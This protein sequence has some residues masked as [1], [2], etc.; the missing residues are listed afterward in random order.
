MKELTYNRLTHTSFSEQFNAFKALYEKFLFNRELSQNEIEKALSISVLFSNQG[1][2]TLNKIGY[3]IALLYAINKNDFKPLYDICINTGITPVADLLKRIEK[4]QNIGQEEDG[5][6]PTII[7]SFIDNFRVGEIVQTEQQVVLNNFHLEKIDATTT[8]VAPTSYGKSELIISTIQKETGKKICILVPSKSLLAQTKRRV[9]ESNSGWINKIITHPDMYSEDNDSSLYIL[10]QERLSRLINKQK[11]FYLDTVFIDEAHNILEKGSRSTLLAS[12]LRVLHYRNRDTAFKFLTPFLEDPKNINLKDVELSTF[13]FKVDEY[14]KAENV[15]I[16]D[17]RN[18][19]KTH[20]LYDPLINDFF[21]YNNDDLDEVEYIVNRSSDK[22]VIYFNRPK[23]IQIFAKILAEKLPKISSAI[24]N[25]AIKEIS[26]F[27][28][29][30]Y[31]LLKCLSKGVVYHHGSMPEAIRQY[32]EYIY[33]ECDEVKYIITSSTLLEGVNLPVEKMF[34][35]DIRKGLEHLRHSQFRNLIGR[36]SRF[37]DVFANPQLGSLEKLVPEIHII[38]TD[39]YFPSVA[40]INNFVRKVMQESKKN[41]DVVENVLINGTKI[42]DDN[43][44]EYELAITRLGNIEEGIISSNTYK[45][46]KT[47][48]GKRLLESNIT[49]INVFECE[50][51]IE[52][53]L[54]SH[55]Q[56][57]GRIKDSNTLMSVIYQAFVANIENNSKNRDKSLTRLKNDKAQTFYAMFLDWNI[58]NTPMGVMI[59]RFLKFWSEL[60][61][62]TP[63]FVGSW[64]DVKKDDSYRELFTYI[65]RKSKDEQVNLA[66]VR[67]KEEEDFVDYNIFQYLD[68]LFDSE[69]I[70][71]NFYKLVKYGTTDESTIS[72][73]QNGF[74]K[75]TAE[76]INNNYI[77]YFTIENNEVKSVRKEIHQKLLDDGVGFMQRNEIAMNVLNK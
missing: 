63:I 57:N 40:N 28:D 30:K 9:L 62:S 6:Y 42:N 4:S 58:E 41:K 19:E 32:V 53:F 10:T 16:S 73:I 50:E 24:V 46:A 76:L 21:P 49:E 35:L 8:V 2:R 29:E 67:I 47:D 66:I 44:K 31:L 7:E 55:L 5:F 65:S 43:R 15:F 54:N 36:V 61:E 17:Y 56:E 11:D 60:P 69:L 33:R 13:S 72:M 38:A 12:T 14:V 74:S 45:I 25:A 70:D 23:H 77:D 34:L 3:K 71:E 27:S 20:K 39:N 37:N 51:R 18:G 68:I 59:G 22:N 75:S 26:D 1:D 48:I 52:Q 64:G